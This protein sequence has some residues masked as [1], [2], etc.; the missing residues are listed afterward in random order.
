MKRTK[1]FIKA[2][3]VAIILSIILPLSSYAIG[4]ESLTLALDR[5]RGE[6]SDG[7][8]P[9]YALTDQ[10]IYKIYEIKNGASNYDRA[11]YCLDMA[12]GFGSGS[13]L[14]LNESIEY[15]KKLNMLDN[16]GKTEIINNETSNNNEGFSQE[17]YDKIVKILKN[18]YIP[19]KTDRNEFL[20][21]T[22]ENYNE[23]DYYVTDKDIEVAQ[24]LAIWH[25]TNEDKLNGLFNG[26]SSSIYTAIYEDENKV[27]IAEIVKYIV[28][29]SGI[30]DGYDEELYE[31]SGSGIKYFNL[32]SQICSGYQELYN[33]LEILDGEEDSGEI[34]DIL[35][36]Y[37]GMWNRYNA[38]NKIYNSMIK[39][40]EAEDTS[41]MPNTK[42]LEMAETQVKI[43]KD[44]I[45]NEEYYIAG[46]FK[47]TKNNVEY[48][49]FN[50]NITDEV[51]NTINDYKLLDVNKTLTTQ[52]IEDLLGK[53][54]YIRV[55]ANAKYRKIKV[56]FTAKYNS[57]TINYWTNASAIATTQPIA[58]V[59]KTPIDLSGEKEVELPITGKYSLKIVK[60]DSTNL[61]KKLSEA[62]FTINN[63]EK[64]A[65]NENGAATLIEDKQIDSAEQADLYKIT[66]KVAPNGYQKF[67]GTIEL[68]V[69][70][71]EEN[72]N[73]IVD[74]D[75]TQITVK[76]QL[77]NVIDQDNPVS[78]DVQSSYI[79]IT[80]KNT[81]NEKP[82]DVSL[83]K[84][85]SEVEGKKYNRAP[86]V[87]V[88]KL[89]PNGED[90]TA[91]YVHSKAPIGVKVGDI[92]TYTIRVYNEGQRDGYIGKVSDYLPEQLDF[93]MPVTYEEV[94]ATDELIPTTYEEIEQRD[95]MQ[96]SD[97][98][99]LTKEEKIAQASE[100]NA[101][102]G[103]IYD[104]ATRKIETTVLAKETDSSIKN[105]ILKEQ[106]RES[107]LLKAFDGENL[108]YID[109]KVKC[110]V[111]EKATVKEEITNIAEI[112]K[113]E[114]ENGNTIN[115]DRDSTPG[116]FPE[117]K[118][119]NNYK[120]NGDDNGYIKGQ[121]DD[122][123][124][125]KIVIQQ[126]DLS[127]RKHIVD[128]D[129]AKTTGREPQVD[130]TPLKN[131]TDTTAIYNHT[132][133][134]LQVVRG[135]II[136]YTINVYNE[137]NVD[138]YVDEITDYLPPEL[139]Y[140]E[141]SEINKQ[142][143]WKVSEDGRKV[144]TD[145]LKY[146]EGKTDN[147]LKAYEGGES[148]STK[149]VQIQCKVKDTAE[150][151]K[152][153]TNLAQITEDSDS[154][155]NEVE[156]RDSTPNGGFE[157]PKD[158]DLPSYKDS[159]LDKSY[160]P[161]QEDDDDFEKVRIVYFDL[162]LRKIVSKAIVIENGNQTITETNHKFEDDPEE[163]VKVDLGRKKLK[164]VTVKFEYQ[165]RITNEGMIEGYA[166]EIKDYI[167][168]GLKFDAKDNPLWKETE[169]GIITTDQL[170]DTLLQPGESKVV[171]VV[172]TWING[173]DNLGLKVNVAEIS[174]D[175]N[176]Y[177]TPDIDSIPDN[178]KDGED[179]IDDA[180]VMLSIALGNA[181][182]YFGLT[183]LMLFTTATGIVLIKKFVL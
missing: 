143:N 34:Q 25:Y 149:F 179:D 16:N 152:N 104:P 102:Y 174:K 107:S 130:T 173:T 87:D 181:K 38:I 21:K 51:G 54:F 42:P 58:I 132:K 2:I 167:P 50:C 116:N 160:I 147:L 15:N 150:F 157:L 60:V 14:N 43:E 172:L 61:D 105:E 89:Y 10:F 91:R 110:K 68:T 108:D 95:S 26:E 180:P 17:D 176:K 72:G 9:A 99:N 98:T 74:K 55:P 13:G 36:K 144:T 35:N 79:T 138:G 94:K 65:T 80:L 62:V 120:G 4:G 46:P 49:D 115:Q 69:K 57:T 70:V 93:I 82:F 5:F 40:A 67:D 90:L 159:E 75:K 153:I 103:W 125:E 135:S 85:I 45:D 122:D 145:Y 170:K 109:L 124:F 63:Q 64:S 100:F 119:N 77:G 164:D 129:G 169:N 83:R 24:Q 27:N 44:T 162:A 133:K 37:K 56:S 84:F 112:T 76:D 12:R 28:E 183:L 106:G 148:L 142:Y 31:G 118:K 168:E 22:I 165:I 182:T 154:E 11:I 151:G 141:D 123:D 127:L 140:I 131:E 66:E 171:T 8:Y 32:N 86:V 7:T 73:Y 53:D 39:I 111:N 20:S 92:V 18:I 1:N 41:V 59:D 47:I 137:G 29:S 139:E 134:P 136:T 6:D 163:I 178:K 114:D 3:I 177:R 121:E 23:N 117:D 113:Y 161:G 156:D 30:E 19:G 81:P 146:T 78:M 97:T 155:G 48:Y 96:N 128:I 52:S 101:K 126:F 88:S 166:K 175:Y 33:Q 158:E 71:K